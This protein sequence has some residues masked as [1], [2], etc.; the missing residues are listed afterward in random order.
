MKNVAVFGAGRMAREVA[1]AA[2]D[3]DE[4]ELAAL[5]SRQCPDWLPDTQHFQ[6][7]AA[8]TA[9]PDLLIDFTLSGGTYDAAHWCRAS[10]VPLVSGTTGLSDR[11]RAAFMEA[12]E[13]VP[14]K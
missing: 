12:S 9:L 10:L 4:L 5:I 6:S 8:L 1:F 13:L 11:D 14:V 7:L 2:T 3:S